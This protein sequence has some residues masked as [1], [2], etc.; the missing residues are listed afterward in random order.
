MNLNQAKQVSELQNEDGR[1]L[2]VQVVFRLRIPPLTRFSAGVCVL[3]TMPAVHMYA[4]L[5]SSSRLPTPVY[6]LRSPSPQANCVAECC[7][8]GATMCPPHGVPPAAFPRWPRGCETRLRVGML[9]SLPRGGPSAP[10]PG[11]RARCLH[12]HTP[13]LV[14][15]CTPTRLARSP[16]ILLHHHHPPSS[17]HHV[18]RDRYRKVRNPHAVPQ[19][20]AASPTRFV[21]PHT[22]DSAREGA[23]LGLPRARVEPEVLHL[24]SAPAHLAPCFPLSR[25]D[26]PPARAFSKHTARALLT[27][28][29]EAQDC[30]PARR[31]LH[32]YGGRCVA[33]PRHVLPTFPPPASAPRARPVTSVSAFSAAVR[34]ANPP[35][36]RVFVI[37]TNRRGWIVAPV[38]KSRPV[39]GGRPPA[40]GGRGGNWRTG[41][42]G[43]RP[44]RPRVSIR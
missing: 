41:D 31:A 7:C 2:I 42:A 8:T 3:Q 6:A 39:R 20:T 37:T 4:N 43:G 15:S 24:F 17:I 23:E 1:C 29:P 26:L 30:Q 13:R 9:P 28:H 10:R 40:A 18:R 36:A 27:P 16:S 21:P 22:D 25:V 11:A 38:D 12:A 35:L 34:A 5:L 14:P 19:L 44:Y 33:R 32:H